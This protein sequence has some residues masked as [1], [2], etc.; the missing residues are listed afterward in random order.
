MDSNK[1]SQKSS[2]QVFCG[3]VFSVTE[4]VTEDP[5][6]RAFERCVVR[7]P[8]AVAVVAVDST[9]QAILVEQYR[10]PMERRVLEIPAGTC[11]VTGEPR[12]ETAKRELAE[13]AGLNAKSWFQLSAIANSPGISNQITTIFLA[14]ELESC[15]TQRS[16]VEEEWMTL[17]RVPLVDLER[18]LDD[19]SLFDATSIIGLLLART[20]LRNALQ[21]KSGQ[22]D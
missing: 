20:H 19:N 16:G 21:E 12:L 6:G 11:D 4:V 5:T 3:Y 7:H 1:F 22:A 14:T 8:G 15:E 18:F 17:R 10:A 13:E 9:T 2:R